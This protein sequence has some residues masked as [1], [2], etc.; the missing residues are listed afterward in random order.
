[1]GCVH[2]Y[3]GDG[4]GKTTAAVGLAVRMAGSG[5]RV[6]TARFLKKDDSGEVASLRLIP[7]ITVI[8]SRKTFGFTWQMTEEQR[9]EAAAYYGELLE[10][11]FCEAERELESWGEKIT[12]EKIQ[13]EKTKAGDALCP[14]V[15]LVLDEVC[16]AVNSGLL[17]EQAVLDRL[18][19][20]PDGL[21]V[22]MTGRDPK[23]SF[24]SRAAYVTEMK[25]IAHPYDCG[26]AARKGIE[27]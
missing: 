13:G 19:R 27:Y 20:R 24:V 2:V 7:G 21:E 10:E 6:V 4:K 15:L 12:G 11:A 9:E 23:G 1:M 17:S 18:D 5:G 14:S 22:V 25:K 26:T 3:C 16:A 8:P